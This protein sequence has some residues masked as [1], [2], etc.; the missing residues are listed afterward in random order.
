MAMESRLQLESL[1]IMSVASYDR[2]I[3]EIVSLARAAGIYAKG[4][5][6]V[7]GHRQQMKTDSACYRALFLMASSTPKAVEAQQ[8]HYPAFDIFLNTKPL[9]LS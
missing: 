1:E 8:T 6:T 2:I 3:S 5:H 4:G 7:Q 9:N